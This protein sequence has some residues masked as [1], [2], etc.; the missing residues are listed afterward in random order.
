[1]V[2]EKLACVTQLLTVAFY[3]SEPGIFIEVSE[4]NGRHFYGRIDGPEDTPYEGG[5]FNVEMYLP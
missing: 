1:M 4:E 2:S 3:V 5:T